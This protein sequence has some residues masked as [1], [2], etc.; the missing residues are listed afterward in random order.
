M[1]ALIYNAIVSPAFNVKDPPVMVADFAMCDIRFWLVVILSTAIALSPRLVVSVLINTFHPSAVLRERM[2]QNARKCAENNTT[3]IP[4]R[5]RW[6]IVGNRE[7]DV[8]DE[9]NASTTPV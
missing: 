8:A 1:F 2:Q 9:R 4:V 6:V 5:V 3:S 7:S